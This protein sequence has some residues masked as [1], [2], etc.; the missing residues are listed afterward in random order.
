MC[1]RGSHPKRF[2]VLVKSWTVT[3]RSDARFIPIMTGYDRFCQTASILEHK[4]QA[5]L[6]KKLDFVEHAVGPTH[7]KYARCTILS[8]GSHHHHHVA[9]EL[10]V[11]MKVK[12]TRK[13]V[14]V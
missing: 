13:V 2:A 8:V 11:V 1:F 6:L 9:H 12:A 14:H 5:H 7:V 10:V 4:P 3:T